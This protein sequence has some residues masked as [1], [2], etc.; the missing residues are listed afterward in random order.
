M[1]DY[2]K[3]L[4]N[5]IPGGAHTYSRG[6]DQ[7]PA[8][9]PQILE[10]GKGAY[11]WAPDGKK[12]LDYGMGLRSVTLGY[13]F[14]QVSH[15]AIAEIHKGNNLTRATLT[16][17]QAAEV[18]TDLIPCA[19]MVKFA[20]N[21]STATT[22]A[23]KLARAYTGKKYIALCS[24]HTFF[25]YDDWFVGTTP[26]VKGVPEENSSLT[27][28]FKYND[29]VSVSALFEKY[30]NQIAAVIL[31]PA[32]NLAPENGYLEKIRELC[33]KNGAVF[34][35][36][37]MIT[38]FRWHLQGAQEYFKVQPDLATFGKGMANGFSLAAL[39]GKRE[40]M[41]L[42]GILKEG[43]ERVFLVSTTHGAEMCA[44][45]AFL[46]TVKVYKQ[47]KVVDHLWS[48]GEQLITGMNAIAAELGIGDHFKVDAYP[49]SPYY[50]TKDKNGQVSLEFRTLFSQEMIRGGVMMPWIALSYSHGKT[51]LEFTLTTTR[52]ALEVYKRALNDGIENHLKSP[53]IKPVFRKYN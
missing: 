6:D 11:V 20:K 18:I 38:G 23:V 36:D 30:P 4:H 33:T 27:L 46:E 22:A 45:G 48:Y 14:D 16:E 52:S 9:A 44:L 3:R 35:L 25:S 51:E 39:V 26:L 8:N 2:R 31:E 28:K 37:E 5:L 49:C 21:G 24:D 40:I 42:A 17:L 1:S 15:A 29:I 13:D 41:D 34:I 7:F 32:T 19:E 47:N 10:R 53:A 50:T 12:Y 43:S